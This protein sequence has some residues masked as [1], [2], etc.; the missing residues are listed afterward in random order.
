VGIGETALRTN[1]YF[2]PYRQQTWPSIDDLAPYFLTPLGIEHWYKSGNDNWGINVRVLYGTLGLPHAEGPETNVPGSEVMADLQMWGDPEF[3]V[4]LIY[5]KVGGGYSDAYASAGNL[6]RLREWVRTL[7][8]D[9]MPVGLYIPFETAWLA[10]KEF[11]QTD[12]ELPKSIEWV[13]VSSLPEN[14]FPVPHAKVPVVESFGYPWD[15]D[16][17]WH[18]KQ[19]KPVNWPPKPPGK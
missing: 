17:A 15:L 14:T 4:L 5:T 9:I 19:P 2:G 8:G 13:A 12:G 3:G 11:M 7:Q 6:S 16:P 1:I 18:S 10:V